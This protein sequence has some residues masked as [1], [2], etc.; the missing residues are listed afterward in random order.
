MVQGITSIFQA[1]GLSAS[2]GLNAYLPLLIV[3]IAAKIGWLPLS[4][5]FDVMTSWWVIGILTVLTLI[6][7]FVDKIPAV[8]TVNDVIN[9]FVRPAAGAILF[10]S[11]A[12][13]VNGLSPVVSISL[14][15]LVAGGVH[16]A[17]STARP[18]VTATTAGV[19]NPI[20]STIEDIISAFTALLAI[21]LP[22]L[23]MLFA[24]LGIVMFLWWRMRRIS[25]QD[26]VA[27]R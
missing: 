16:A 11:T 27:S 7:A 19:G 18:V 2:A 5:P 17:K 26:A 12:D 14:G 25:K 21:L 15:L 10:A 20:V 1:F 23:I 24:V 9:T 22:G 4:K 6:E 3:S 8:D 13:V